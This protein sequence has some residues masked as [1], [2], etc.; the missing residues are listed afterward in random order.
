MIL[1]DVTT[2]TKCTLQETR[3]CA[4]KFDSR[5]SRHRFP[6]LSLFKTT[7]EKKSRFIHL[8]VGRGK[9]RIDLRQVLSFPCTLFKRI[10]IDLCLSS[11][12]PHDVY[13][14]KNILLFVL[15]C[16]LSLLPRL[17]CW[18]ILLRIQFVLSL[19]LSFSRG[20]LLASCF[21]TSSFTVILLGFSPLLLL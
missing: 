13:L 8:G 6:V 12:T 4:R 9:K 14:K 7:R 16:S 15:F 2:E 19:S 3:E 21:L 10:P 5:D 1:E 18:R 11:C 17:Y 20:F